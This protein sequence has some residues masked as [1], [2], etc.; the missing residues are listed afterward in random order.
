MNLPAMLRHRNRLL[1][2][3]YLAT[4]LFFLSDL[5]LGASFRAAALDAHPTWKLAYYAFGFAMGLVLLVRPY[6]A[7]WVGIADGSLSLFLL[8]LG[9]FLPYYDLVDTLAAGNM[10]TN[11]APLSRFA[12]LN[13][14]LS[15]GI[16]VFSLYRYM[17]VAKAKS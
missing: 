13:F 14:L 2:I 5:I 6:A 1:V 9:V 15:G 17:E 16:L 8:I 10:E 3:L 7:H 4:P 12:V 11:I